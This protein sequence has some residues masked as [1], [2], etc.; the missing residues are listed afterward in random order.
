MPKN[1]MAAACSCGGKDS[2]STA[3]EMGCISPAPS[4]WRMRKNTKTGSV[5]E[6][7]QNIEDPTK[8]KREMM[9]SR[10]RPITEASHAVSGRMT[11]T[12]TR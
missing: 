10:F 6:S 5:C 1:P 8:M 12:A 2:R 7:P 3:C 4:P 9:Y 11:T